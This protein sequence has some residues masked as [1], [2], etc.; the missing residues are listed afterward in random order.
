ME[1]IIYEDETV[2]ITDKHFVVGSKTYVLNNITSTDLEKK[3]TIGAKIIGL[4]IFVSG[5]LLSINGF[6]TN[7]F[8]IFL[9]G[10]GVGIVGF[11]FFLIKPKY[12]V[13]LHTAGGENT[14][15]VSKDKEQ[16]LE[17]LKKLNQTI[18]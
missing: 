16:I 17:I 11:F 6:N 8:N 5:V 7:D 12:S 3:G 9:T 4:F 1:N 2:R 18:G 10:I 14:A 15:Y 13:I